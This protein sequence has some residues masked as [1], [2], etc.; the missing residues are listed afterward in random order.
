MMIGKTRKQ[1][2]RAFVP[3]QKFCIGL[4]GLDLM[5][6]WNSKIPDC[7]FPTHFNFVFN[8]QDYTWHLLEGLQAKSPFTKMSLLFVKTSRAKTSRPQNVHRLTHCWFYDNFQL[9]AHAF[10]SDRRL[11]CFF[12]K[13]EILMEIYFTT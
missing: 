10:I 9:F 3:V 5:K 12:K 4:C 11:L 6:C 7:L 13:N 8:L 2:L 1:S